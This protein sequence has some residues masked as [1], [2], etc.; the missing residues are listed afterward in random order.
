M[1][2]LLVPMISLTSELLVPR[3]STN[4]STSGTGLGPPA[5]SGA[6]EGP[7]QGGSPISFAAHFG[8]GHPLRTDLPA[9]REDPKRALADHPLRQR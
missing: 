2:G 4:F 3:G 8:A 5:P 9:D 6:H 7:F 1:N